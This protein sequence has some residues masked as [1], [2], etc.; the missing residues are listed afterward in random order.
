MVWGK[1]AGLSRFPAFCEGA[2][3]VFKQLVVGVERIGSE[4]VQVNERM[5]WIEDVM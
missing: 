2:M 5:E 4:L 1:S 3:R